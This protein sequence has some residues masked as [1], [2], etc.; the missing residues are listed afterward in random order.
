MK[1]TITSLNHEVATIQ[2][3]DKKLMVFLDFIESNIAVNDVLE[4][5]LFDQ[6]EEYI[7]IQ[8]LISQN[9]NKEKHLQNIIN[10]TYYAYG[11]IISVDPVV[12]D[13][14]DLIID[15]PT[16]SSDTSLIGK[17]I[18]FAIQNLAA[19]EI[20]EYKPTHFDKAMDA[21]AEENYE[22]AL[23]L[24]KTLSDKGNSTAYYYLGKIY[25]YGYGTQKDYKQAFSYFQLSAQ[26]GSSKAQCFLGYMYAE[27]I[28]T[29]Q[30]Y[31]L[32]R[33]S[34]Q[35]AASTN[36]RRSIS[37][38]GWIYFKGLGVKQN[39]KKAYELF[40][41]ANQLGDSYASAMLAH[42]YYCGYYVKQDFKEAIKY[43]ELAIERGDIHS[44]YNLG[45]SY[46]KG[47][48]VIQ[49]KKE[50]LRLVRLAAE[51]GDKEAIYRLSLFDKE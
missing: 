8:D 23:K 21:Y 10:T 45:S 12:C 28:G 7:E 24:F 38:L 26:E 16:D 1:A 34:F 33:M 41:K 31:S 29:K 17:F 39:Y 18:G 47:T 43:Y 14:G 50:G 11:E 19:W 49:N 48:G 30:S 40:V 37:G 15:V 2:I 44:I 25:Y 22:E 46:Y 9:K 3:G 4:V 35:I 42:L 32:A 6:G 20:I 36:N 5:D 27:G 51:K 13:V